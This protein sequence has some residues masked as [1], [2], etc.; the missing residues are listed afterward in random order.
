VKLRVGTG[1]V[2]RLSGR[3][4]TTK[5]LMAHSTVSDRVR[6]QMDRRVRLHA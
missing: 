5:T 6:V 4:S 2:Q 1:N 3:G